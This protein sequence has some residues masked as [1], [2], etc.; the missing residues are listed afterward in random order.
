MRPV[1]TRIKFPSSQFNC[2]SGWLTN[3]AVAED[4]S[5][6]RPNTDYRQ[7]LF[8]KKERRKE[9]GNQKAWSE[10]LS[11]K[12][13]HLIQQSST[14]VELLSQTK[15]SSHN[16]LWPMQI[17]PAIRGDNLGSELC[18]LSTQQTWGNVKF[19]SGLFC[20]FVAATNLTGKNMDRVCVYICL[21]FT[22]FFWMFSSLLSYLCPSLC[23]RGGSSS[24]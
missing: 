5:G 24:V 18:A 3:S 1:T 17:S 8:V 19:S 9:R 14:I 20:F 21:T 11:T 10:N 23:L 7:F 6:S 16:Y 4:C 22:A 13:E 15:P 2:N 12:G